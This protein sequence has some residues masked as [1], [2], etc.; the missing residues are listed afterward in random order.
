[1]NFCSSCGARVSL[2]IPD[3]DNLP[4]HVC[5]ACGQ[6]HYQNPKVVVGAIPVLGERILLARRAIEPRLGLWTLPA[7][8]MENGETTG[9]AAIRETL[10]EACADIEV[11][12]LF[13]LVN[14]PHISQIHLFY[15][16]RMRTERFAPGSES[17]EVRLFNQ[18]EI[19]WDEIAFRSSTLT[20][21]HYFEDRA[22]GNFSF[23]S[24]DLTQKRSH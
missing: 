18:D 3:G 8:F 11:N 9:E 2:R 14:I 21:Q 10:E 16:A 15:L 17:L 23:H 13:S 7:G 1:M 5:G 20:L 19:P 24:Q 4:R 12:Q 6:I 22:Q